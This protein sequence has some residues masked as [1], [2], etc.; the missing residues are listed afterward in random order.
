VVR[1]RLHG[2]LRF[3]QFPFLISVTSSPSIYPILNGLQLVHST[4]T[5]THTHIYIFLIL[6][7]SGDASMYSESPWASKHHR[8]FRP[9]ALLWHL[10]FIEFIAVYFVRVFLTSLQRCYARWALWATNGIFSFFFFFRGGDEA[11]RGW[12]CCWRWDG[13]FLPSHI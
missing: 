4:H 6:V 8:A 3:T 9:G 7:S 13:S 1:S 10:G 12:E 11:W 5:H 2:R